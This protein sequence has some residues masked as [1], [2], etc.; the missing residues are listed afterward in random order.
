[1]CGAVGASRERV[2]FDTERHQR[3]GQALTLCSS[4]IVRTK[5]LNRKERGKSGLCVGDY[6]IAFAACFFGA[7]D[8]DNF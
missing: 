8:Q 2:A 3:R 5:S 6:P 7:D 1:M 4:R